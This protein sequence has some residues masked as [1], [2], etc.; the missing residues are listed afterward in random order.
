MVDPRFAAR[1]D[2]ANKRWILPAGDYTL[3]LATSAA[4][5][6]LA[7]TVSLPERTFAVDWRP[8]DPLGAVD[9]EN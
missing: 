8:A 5:P 6:G 7:T 3:R 9:T 1:F 2:V 4:D